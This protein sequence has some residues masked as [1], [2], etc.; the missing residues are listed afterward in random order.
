M[1][2]R[3]SRRLPRLPL[4]L[5]LAGFIALRL[6]LVLANI[7]ALH[8]LDRAEVKHFS[9]SG[10]LTAHDMKGHWL[11]PQG[12]HGGYT[13]N[14]ILYW[15]LARFLG[16]G[17]LTLKCVA[18]LFSAATLWT[19]M[20]LLRRFIGPASALLFAA[21]FS[22]PSA[23]MI[24]WT[25]TVW[26]S[27][28]ESCFFSALTVYLF[29][30]FFHPAPRPVGPKG[31]ILFGAFLGLSAY[32]SLLILPTLFLCLVFY[33]YK[34][35]KRSFI[36]L[37]VMLLSIAAVF[38][39]LNYLKWKKTNYYLY[40]SRGGELVRASL[41]RL[42][43]D[44]FL[45]AAL[46]NLD[47]PVAPMVPSHRRLEGGLDLKH[48]NQAAS[49]VLFLAGVLAL[50]RARPE[51]R[52]FLIFL[53]AYPLVYFL[54][55]AGANPQ[56]PEIPIRYLIVG[57]PFLFA[58]MGAAVSGEGST[59]GRLHGA[60]RAILGVGLAFSLFCGM[61]EAS[62]LFSRERISRWGEFRAIE[63]V[64]LKIG[65]VH[66]EFLDGVNRFVDFASSRPDDDRVAGFRIVFPLVS[67]YD[68][69]FDRDRC[70]GALPD[71]AEVR[72]A[73]GK[74]EQEGRRPEALLEGVG[75]AVGLRRAGDRA[76]CGAIFGRFAPDD[77]SSLWRGF[78]L[79]FPGGTPPPE[80]GR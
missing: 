15:I 30:R 52:G 46:T 24:A 57:L 34:N 74:L 4:L 53:Y 48:L 44:E 78:E 62:A 63:Y 76:G 65:R 14:I 51:C 56:R 31:S 70:V 79:G 17:Y 19:W 25:S 9:L 39:P 72:A 80:E 73:V 71:P 40:D 66:F 12:L 75:W 6:M 3:G 45:T 50:V 35:G 68:C 47:W 38:G 2:E 22:L 77:P 20:A 64:N 7:D 43:L 27:H 61:R 28:P 29:F 67:Y 5:V 69:L 60:V 54:F 23:A 42:T 59:K 1:K 33:A 58:C 13:L 21:L 11:D 10:E 16:E 41:D 32:F 37:A 8:E 26:G 55:L 18:L 49:A 36:P